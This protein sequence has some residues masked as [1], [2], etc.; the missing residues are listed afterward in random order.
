M[1]PYLSFD[2]IESCNVSIH[3]QFVTKKSIHV[4]FVTLNKGFVIYRHIHCGK[5]KHKNRRMQTSLPNQKILYKKVECTSNVNHS[6][7]STF[8]EGEF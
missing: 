8:A 7:M 2:R 4:Q 6:M 1:Q 5:Q 3:V